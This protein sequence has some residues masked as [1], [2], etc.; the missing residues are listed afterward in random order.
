MNREELYR[1]A[2][3]RIANPIAD[4]QRRAEAE[5]TVLNGMMCVAMANDHHYLK[6]LAK[7]AL[8]HG[9]ELTFES[10]QTDDPGLPW[11]LKAAEAER[12]EL[13]SAILD[14][15]NVVSET[16][17]PEGADGAWYVSGLEGAV[18]H[19]RQNS[20]RLMDERDRLRKDWDNALHAA[21]STMRSELRAA[22]QELALLRS[23]GAVAPHQA[24][25]GPAPVQL[26]VTRDI[27]DAEREGLRKL[28]AEYQAKP[29]RVSIIPLDHLVGL[30]VEVLQRESYETAKEK[31]WH[32][33]D[34]QPPS[35]AM[36]RIAADGLYQAARCKFIEAYRKGERGDDVLAGVD[37]MGTVATLSDRQVRVVA[38]LALINTEVAEAIEDVVAGRWQ[39]TRNEKGKPE[40]LGSELADIIIRACDDAGAL[41]IDLAAELR[42][43]MDYNRTRAHRHGGK[44]A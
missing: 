7:E 24:H 28:V 40:G 3:E 43:K 8:A 5:G 33:E 29:G 36:V 22:L 6:G 1:A 18:D 27:T 14:V 44:L 41:G 9:A 4:M 16:E 34:D 42:A 37:P 32:D 25:D 13:R 12:D 23:Q 11:R 21:T 39:T 35:E 15:C 19:L 2:L 38:W 26:L 20:R 30:T 10:A 17:P 31:G